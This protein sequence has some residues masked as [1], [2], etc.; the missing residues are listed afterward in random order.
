MILIVGTSSRFLS[1]IQE[2]EGFALMVEF[3]NI[4]HCREYLS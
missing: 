2:D 4:G 3:F 1:N